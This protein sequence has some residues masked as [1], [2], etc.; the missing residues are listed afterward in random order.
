MT[1]YGASTGAGTPRTAIVTGGTSGIGKSVAVRLV[2]AGYRVVL[3]YS[4]NDDRAK[5]ALAECLD[6]APGSAVLVKAD[7]SSRTAV[8]EMV[9]ETVR[10]F[11]TLDVLINNAAVALDKP[12]LDMTEDEWDRVIDVNLKGPFLCSQT[13]ARQMLRQDEGGAIINVGSSTGIRGRRN[14]V[15][16]C[17]SK[18]GLMLMTQCLALE[19]G[20]NV[21]VNTIIPGM[22]AT[23]DA[24]LRFGLDDP[25]KRRALEAAVPMGRLGTP[26][27]VAG[28]VMLLLSDDARFI[29]G[30]KLVVDGGQ[31]MW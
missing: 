16:T 20:P 4:R 29:T 30:Q 7:V 25:E 18:A 1:G 26:Q 23:D 22:T 13:A 2:Q 6:L 27:D 3:N 21:R 31:Y 24:I 11:S 28:A 14:G 19:L 5:A 15:N 9:A 17:A 12:A 8:T 10:R